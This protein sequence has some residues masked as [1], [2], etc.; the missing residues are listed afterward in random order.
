MLVQEGLSQRKS[1][2]IL[3]FCRSRLFYR[4]RYNGEKEVLRQRIKALAKEYPRYGYRR[5]DA[6]LRREG[7]TG[8]IK[9]VHRLWKQEKLAVKK[10]LLKQKR[11]GQRIAFPP[12]ALYP[13]HVWT[14]DFLQENLT[15]GKR[16]RLLALIDEY[17][18]ECLTIEVARSMGSK[19]VLACLKRVVA[20]RGI[21]DYIRSDNGSEFIAQALQMWLESVGTQCLFIRPGS[22]WENGK[23]ESFNGKFRDEFLN[24]EVF[25][26]LLQAQVEVEW[27]RKYYN[28][29]R[30]H[31]ALG[32]KTPEEFA[33][34]WKASATL[35]PSIAVCGTIPQSLVTSGTN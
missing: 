23:C 11:R 12:Q 15:N 30:P 16:L 6:L 17:T 29:Q 24:R 10:R 18:R 1:C 20:K 33:Q 8:N 31:S 13:N 35:Q 34:Q 32:Y 25:H 28:Q 5:V 22:P 21:P 7:F 4:P 2:E 9:Q 27:W 26:S 19:E 3:E 14:Y